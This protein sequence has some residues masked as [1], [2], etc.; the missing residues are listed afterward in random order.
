MNAHSQEHEQ[1]AREALGL[2]TL[3]GESY[4]TMPEVYQFLLAEKKRL[5]IQLRRGDTLNKACF[6]DYPNIPFLK[7]ENKEVAWGKLLEMQVPQIHSIIAQIEALRTNYAYRSMR[8]L[9]VDFRYQIS[10]HGRPK[11]SL[12]MAPDGVKSAFGGGKRSRRGPS[13]SE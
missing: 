4:R 8:A 5:R 10:N 12:A 2:W 3:Y 11:S 7:I 6:E 13:N 1:L 9:V